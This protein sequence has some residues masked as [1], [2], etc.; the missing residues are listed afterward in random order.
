[1][2]SQIKNIIAPAGIEISPGTIKIGTKYAKTLFVFS[3]P[4]YLSTGWFSPIVNYP[5]L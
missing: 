2:D 5:D 4:R 3:Y 1:M